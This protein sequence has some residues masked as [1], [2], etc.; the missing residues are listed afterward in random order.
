MGGGA[1]FF[2]DSQELY[3]DRQQLS[4]RPRLLVSL[5]PPRLLVSTLPPRNSIGVSR[6]NLP[7]IQNATL[8]TSLGNLTV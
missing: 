8:S 2:Y 6:K 1:D 5:L 7:P 4:K 3:T